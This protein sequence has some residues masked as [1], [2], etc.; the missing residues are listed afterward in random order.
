MTAR[1]TSIREKTRGHRFCWLSPLR[2]ADRAYSSHFYSNNSGMENVLI[3]F[4]AAVATI[5]SL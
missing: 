2:F 1:F 5:T 4:P 3:V